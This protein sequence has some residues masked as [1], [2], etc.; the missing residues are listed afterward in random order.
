MTSEIFKALYGDGWIAKADPAD[1]H[2]P[3]TQKFTLKR[4]K[5]G[6]LVADKFV[7]GAN[8]FA[9]NEIA[10]ATAENKAK[11]KQL[12]RAVKDAIDPK[13]SSIVKFDDEKRQVF[14]WAQ[15]ASVNGE[16][17]L[18]RQGDMVTIEELSKAAHDFVTNSRKGGIMHRR[19]ETDE[20]VQVGHVIESIIVDEPI[21]KALGLPDSTPEGWFIGMQVTDERAW[22]DYKAGKFPDFSVHGTGKRKPVY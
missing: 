11:G 10:G 12:K 22:D 1:V 17:V 3:T 8:V 2:V 15:V 19:T 9:T 18:D 6:G 21:K 7:P 14:G 16:P 13:R 20:P 5:R 4:T